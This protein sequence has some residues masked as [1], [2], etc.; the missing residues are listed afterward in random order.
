MSSLESWEKQLQSKLA[1]KP[2]PQFETTFWTRFNKEFPQTKSSHTLWQSLMTLWPPVV[3]FATALFILIS[4]R[5][6]QFPANVQVPPIQVGMMIEMQPAL[7]NLYTF[8]E[9]DTLDLSEQEL[10]ILAGEDII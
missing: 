9:L 10:K 6:I 7:D 5:V 8:S 4:W 3:S 2:G 1:V